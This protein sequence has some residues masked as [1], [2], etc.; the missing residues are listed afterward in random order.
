MVYPSPSTVHRLAHDLDSECEAWDNRPL[1]VHYRLIYLD[2]VYFPLLH[3]SSRNQC[4]VLVALGVDMAGDKEVEAVK[5]GNEESRASW[6][7]LLLEL[8]K[9]DS[10]CQLGQP[11]N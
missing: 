11:Q 6:E 2:A 1:A 9:R 3:E 7:T 5:V 8:Q 10:L 4:A